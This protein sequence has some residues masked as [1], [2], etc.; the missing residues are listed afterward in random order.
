MPTC[1]DLEEGSG[2]GVEV[3]FDEPTGGA[4]A[5][6]FG[7]TTSD[8]DKVVQYAQRFAVYFGNVALGTDEDE[9]V[10]LPRRVE[11]ARLTECSVT[12]GAGV[13]GVWP[14]RLVQGGACSPSTLDTVDVLIKNSGSGNYQKFIVYATGGR[15]DGLDLVNMWRV[16]GVYSAEVQLARRGLFERVLPVVAT[17]AGSAKVV[18]TPD[19]AGASGD[20]YLLFYECSDNS[21]VNVCPFSRRSADGVP[22]YDVQGAPAFA[23]RVS[24]SDAAGFVSP[25][26]ITI[27]QGLDCDPTVP[28]LRFAAPDSAAACNVQVYD[29]GVDDL[30]YWP[31]RVVSGGYC[32][33]GGFDEVTFS[34]TNSGHGARRLVV[35]ST[36]GRGYGLDLAR[37]CANSSCVYRLS[38][39]IQVGKTGLRADYLNLGAGET[40]GLSVDYGMADY[41]G[42]VYLLAYECENGICPDAVDLNSPTVFSVAK[43]PLFIVQAG[44]TAPRG[45]YVDPRSLRVAEGESGKY[46]VR[47]AAPPAG[48]VTIAV[49]AVPSSAVSLSPD[50]LTF[51]SSNWS[52]VQ[53]VTVSAPDDVDAD[54]G[55]ARITH[56]AT[57]ARYEETCS[58]GCPVDVTIEDDDDMGVRLSETAL[59]VVEGDVSAYTISLD[60][61]P[62]GSVAVALS[63]E[64]GRGVATVSPLLLNFTP[65]DWLAPQTVTVTGGYDDVVHDVP[66]TASVSHEF[67]GGGYDDVEAASVEVTVT[68]VVPGITVS[69]T[70]LS[71][72]EDGSA[73]YTVVLD[74]RPR[75]S[76]TVTPS[77]SPSSGVVTVSPSSL[78]FTVDDWNVPQTFTLTGVADA[79]VYSTARTA[80][81]SHS[82][83][84]SGYDSL[85][86][87]AVAVAIF[88]AHTA[89]VVLSDYTLSMESGGYDTYTVVLTAQ[90]SGEVTF[91]AVSSSTGTASVSP[92]TLTFTETNW[93]TPQTITVRG[94]ADGQATVTHNVSGGGYAGV[95]VGS[96]VVTVSGGTVVDKGVA[97]SRSALSVA[98]GSSVAYTLVLT[99]EPTGEVTVLVSNSDYTKTSASP[100]RVVF[101]SGN[102]NVPQTVTVFGLQTGSAVMSHSIFGGGYDSVTV[103]SVAVIITAGAVVKQVAFSDDDMA[104]GI[105]VNHSGTY[106]LVLTSRPT[107]DVVVSTVSDA[108][109]VATVSP[110]SVTFTTGN[111]N[112]PQSFTVNGVAL[113]SA[114]ISHSVSGG[115]YGGLTLAAMDVSVV[116]ATAPGGGLGGVNA[117]FDG[118]GSNFRD[119]LWQP[120]PLREAFAA[121]A[122]PWDIAWL[123]P[124]R[125]S[126]LFQPAPV[127]YGSAGR[128]HGF[129][130]FSSDGL[131]NAAIA[132]QAQRGWDWFG[133][134][135]DIDLY[136]FSPN[137]RVWAYLVQVHDGE[138]APSDCNPA[139][140]ST[141]PLSTGVVGSDGTYKFSDILISADLFEVGLNYVCAADALGLMLPNPLVL[142]V[143]EPSYDYRLQLTITNILQG[144]MRPPDFVRPE[145]DFK[146]IDGQ[147][148]AG[149]YE[150]PMALP[151]YHGGGKTT[152]LTRTDGILRRCYGGSVGGTVGRVGLGAG[153]RQVGCE[154]GEH[155]VT[156]P[157][158]VGTVLV[159]DDDSA[160][161][162]PGDDLRFRIGFH[163]T[164]FT[165]LEKQRF[166][167][168]WGPVDIWSLGAPAQGNASVV[169]ASEF[170]IHDAHLEGLQTKLVT[171]SDLDDNGQYELV[172]NRDSASA[173]GDTFVAVVPCNQDYLGA[174]AARGTVLFRNQRALSDCGIPLTS[175]INFDVTES[176]AGDEDD[177]P[178]RLL[179][180]AW[181]QHDVTSGLGMSCE[182]SVRW[183]RTGDPGGYEY[184]Y[185]PAVTC[186]NSLSS[187]TTVQAE[188]CDA[189]LRSAHT[190]ADRP[191]D[192]NLGWSDDE[193]THMVSDLSCGWGPP[194]PFIEDSSRYW[195]STRYN[196]ARSAYAFVVDWYRDSGSRGA[197]VGCG[198]HLL[199]YRVNSDGDAV[200]VMDDGHP[201]GTRYWRLGT[202]P[203]NDVD[204]RGVAGQDSVDV[205]FLMADADPSWSDYHQTWHGIQSAHFALYVSGLPAEHDH[206][207]SGADV[208]SSEGWRRV[209]LGGWDWR[210]GR[211]GLDGGVRRPLGMALPVADGGSGGDDVSGLSLASVSDFY[212]GRSFKVPRHYA[213]K[214]GR[215]RLYVVP[216]L[217]N[218]AE[219]TM[220]S[221]RLCSDLAAGAGS[222][223]PLEFHQASSD[224][225]PFGLETRLGVSQVLHYSYVITVTFDDMMASD[226]VVPVP[227]REVIPTGDVC[228]AVRG[229]TGEWPE[230]LIWK[231]P[232]DRSDLAPADVVFA[233]GGSDYSA[234][235]V[236]AT[237]GRSDGLDLT[238]LFRADSDL[239]SSTNRLGR[240]GLLERLPLQLAAGGRQVVRVTPDMAG[241]DGDIWLLAYHCVG[242]AAVQMC[243]QSSREVVD[244]KPVYSLPMSSSFVVRVKYADVTHSGLGSIC[245][246]SDC[247]PP[248]PVLRLSGPDGDGVCQVDA[249]SGGGVRDLTYWPD[250]VVEG[251]ACEPDSDGN[252][253]VIVRN[254]TAYP[255]KMVAYV[256][257]G[258]SS[259]LAKV[260]VRRGSGAAGDVA[261]HLAGAVGLRREQHLVVAGGSLSLTIDAGMADDDGR[262]LLLAYD[263]ALGD[264]SDCPAATSA[265]DPVN[266]AVQRR[267]LF[268]VLV[269]YDL[270][271]IQR[272]GLAICKGDD[273]QRSY[274]L[275]RYALPDS[276]GCGISAFGSG[277]GVHWPRGIIAGGDCDVDTLTE[278]PV[279]FR[280]PS[281]G[282]TQRLR[283]YATGRR[284]PQLDE[285]SVWRDEQASMDAAL[286]YYADPA[287][288]ALPETPSFAGDGTPG[289]G[290][291]AS[292]AN[293]TGL[294]AMHNTVNMRWVLIRHPALYNK[295]GAK[296]WVTDGLNAVEKR[297][298]DSLLYLAVEQPQNPGVALGVVDMSFMGG[299]SVDALDYITVMA[300]FGALDDGRLTAV[301]RVAGNDGIS[302]AERRKVIY[303]SVMRDNSDIGL[304]TDSYFAVNHVSGPTSAVPITELRP[305][306]A[307]FDN[308]ASINRAVGYLKSKMGSP[309]PI[310]HVV[311]VA[312]S[313]A[314][315]PNSVGVNYGGNVISYN[316]APE[317]EQ[318]GDRVKSTIIHEVAHYYWR[319]GEVW[320]VEGMASAIEKL[321]ADAFA[322]ALPDSVTLKVKG[323]CTHRALRDLVEAAPQSGDPQFYCNYYLG[324]RLFLELHDSLGAEE[325]WVGA[326]SLHSA[327]VDCRAAGRD[328]CGRI[329]DVRNAFPES[330]HVIDRHWHGGVQVPTVGGE[331]DAVLGRMGVY[332]AYMSVI[333]DG[334][335]QVLVNPDMA[336][337]KGH[338][339]LFGYR[340]DGADD[341]SCP[342]VARPAVNGYDLEVGPDFAVLVRFTSESG[343]AAADLKEV[344]RGQQCDI[345]HP[346]LRRAESDV[347]ECGARLGT[348]WPDRVISG[349]NCWFR[350]TRYGEVSFENLTSVDESFVVYATGDRRGGYGSLPV[351]GVL[352][353]A[354]EGVQLGQSGLKEHRLT[355]SA[356]GSAQIY[357][358]TDMADDDGEVWLFVYRCLSSHVDVGCPLVGS[359]AVRPVYDIG[360]RPTFVV[361][362]G[363]LNSADGAMSKLYIDCSAGSSCVLTAVFRDSAGNSLP[364]TAEFR[365]DAGSLGAVDSTAVV[366]Q[367]GHVE[368]AE[369]FQ[370]LETLHLPAGGGIVNVTVEL[371]G[372]GLE[373][374]GRAGRAA[375]LERLSLR[376][377]RCSGDEVSCHSGALEKASSL[378]RGD[379]FVVEVSGLDAS[380]DVG[381]DANLR[382]EQVCTDG[383]SVSWPVVWLDSSG[384]RSH[385]YGTG[386]LEDRGYAGCAY[387]VTDDA[388]YGSH[389]Y[390]VTYSSGGVPLSASGTVS[391]VR[392]PAG[393]SF[394]GL[395][396]PARLESGQTGSFR[397]L[398]Y[399]L[400]GLPLEL[401]DG[402]VDLDVTGALSGGDECAV[403][404][405]PM[406]GATFEVTADDDVVLATDSSVGVTYRG[407]SVRRHVL[408]VPVGQP[409]D[410]PVVAGVS[411]ITGLTVTP[412][413]SQLRLNWS[414]TP[415][416]NFASL[417]AQ[418]WVLVGDEDVFLPGCSGGDVLATSTVEV[419][420]MM[421]HGQS[422]DVYH[423]AVGFFR[424]DGT[425]VPVETAEWTR[426]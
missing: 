297:L 223:L 58:D 173:L 323:R 228:G 406:S 149:A 68:D 267:P 73:T 218:Y 349:G 331:A 25:A 397:L 148:Y 109:D 326:R 341:Y 342:R 166:A 234:L 352:R 115:S 31:D 237:G 418:V 247:T 107:G 164:Q 106:S 51:D 354:E 92:S 221:L 407:L 400:A 189:K 63:V 36:G 45:V 264:A 181:Q 278:V 179:R 80:T 195:A 84:G 348:H 147:L 24:Y 185:E 90:P 298:L 206:N 209:Y 140:R 215:V 191:S 332:E 59:T 130:E 396:G 214:G 103:P 353:D 232:C 219:R 117:A 324:Q 310:D 291:N 405:I 98:T 143:Y 5:G 77:V 186:H 154:W 275:G 96:V 279:E 245:Q 190:S 315:L 392:D 203:R 274:P 419:F 187:V 284:V 33:P 46:G 114:R 197:S 1:T 222:S 312:D 4:V 212:E 388:E 233:N 88:D 188:H 138:D 288:R 23:V 82:A 356:G 2:S 27:C 250:R 319:G 93:D 311:A 163:P 393:L 144:T 302:E 43:R 281:G 399:N 263:C 370:F 420:C 357:V 37:V 235:A 236:Y 74:S 126:W 414:S 34:V 287:Y 376:V 208:D 339:W 22:P 134:Y 256:T 217:P 246:G 336:D 382:T 108:V 231:G 65:L 132:P 192:D 282:G 259:G 87:A 61:Q 404:G 56:S 277:G 401:T 403:T 286:P 128:G 122:V 359:S 89:N 347:G 224:A 268:Q 371:L 180:M 97:V 296:A 230:A 318:A 385:P 19:M 139:G 137:Q 155:D 269:G 86:I 150:K 111:W 113:G 305:A 328:D 127:S 253:Q 85:D 49:S 249:W 151:Q 81:V 351:Y 225:G 390:T 29:G 365:V 76:V 194:T 375:S 42:N 133:D 135:F 193:I 265:G 207:F 280:V 294:L 100:A 329:A 47:L 102:W 421:S 301:L 257:G 210:D 162:I 402:C 69:E 309:F 346:W 112:H 55:V 384:L 101:G 131:G 241:A 276:A 72:Y 204:C 313:K 119:S 145:T 211:I 350:G 57:G 361:R 13:N 184:A 213:D 161:Q 415:T 121:P 160:V 158:K 377:M 64:P 168:F 345:A 316:P 35:Y 343:L 423:A 17:S 200:S 220:L 372:D 124:P 198:V 364:G 307:A 44:L 78:V 177:D 299:S 410:P 252:L 52:E 182:V 338:V 304:V 251:G 11:T 62:T 157:G 94:V 9:P 183:T 366:S 424:Y 337:E 216:C 71:F 66:R 272:S 105:V 248:M 426:P 201:V 243:P 380:G 30:T 242:S 104:M 271:V 254:T 229:E 255:Q 116:S 373:L 306:A 391:V 196:L 321:G 333:S 170:A 8:S 136:G 303:A 378:N 358:R 409:A 394:L 199:R 387:R 50:T 283:I 40:G 289:S 395:T 32:A 308:T 95:R 14:E 340:C 300:L 75:G 141:L 327:I 54:D 91:T 386:Q 285:V 408:V 83:V 123:E 273:C 320:V 314:L 60:S 260:Q 425:A 169:K 295:M 67:T 227:V 322:Q 79:E 293:P 41:N 238:E 258:R 240:L 379:R 6:P 202:A 292:I 53:E 363:F 226:N 10:S 330:A 381:L 175:A 344:C 244:G 335:A 48:P 205:N 16:G 167:V 142:T 152:Y 317:G 129:W 26:R 266:F 38:G 369:E 360:V 422:G 239:D 165:G 172:I 374:T 362:T 18:V 290:G 99:E 28:V 398:G 174:P 171:Q 12:R 413:G 110:A 412:E 156:V 262:I 15:S 3:L 325:F 416:A 355:A 334:V 368:S 146:V 153:V 176:N 383:V 21:A 7:V 389:G 159:D 39:S 367:V 417:R 70:S 178:L 270:V 411:H 120:Q 125:P 20:V 261:G 118:S